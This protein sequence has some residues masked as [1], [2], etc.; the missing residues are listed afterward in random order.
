MNY[1]SEEFYLICC[2]DFIF[3]GKETL[4]EFDK[5]KNV[6]R[7]GGDIVYTG[8][9]RVFGILRRKMFSKYGYKLCF[10]EWQSITLDMY[11][12]LQRAFERGN[13]SNSRLTLV[14]MSDSN[15]PALK[16]NIP[17]WDCYLYVTRTQLFTISKTLPIT[18]YLALFS[19]LCKS[20]NSISFAGNT[21]GII[22]STIM[23]CNHRI[24][25]N[26]WDCNPV[27]KDEVCRYDSSCHT[28]F[29][30]SYPLLLPEE[31]YV[32]CED[33]YYLLYLLLQRVN[34]L[35]DIPYYA[36]EFFTTN[37]DS[38]NMLVLENLK[39]LLSSCDVLCASN[40]LSKLVTR[41]FMIDIINMWK[42]NEVLVRLNNEFS[43]E[44]D[45]KSIIDTGL[46]DGCLDL[47]NLIV[48]PSVKGSEYARN[49]LFLSKTIMYIMNSIGVS[50]KYF[51]REFKRLNG[52]AA[53]WT[54]M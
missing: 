21:C 12:L 7:Y 23:E 4:F 31:S 17:E 45:V 47:F 54:I 8:D 27:I 42:F 39:T 38:S 20:L 25:L 3:N 14:A 6:L 49:M 46:H 32:V 43:N 22:V 35:P 13:S 2:N 5:N 37:F 24:L 41:L 30:G 53:F 10:G 29:C 26:W 18:D 50:Y 19:M 51:L 1:T 36:A 11:S 28:L 9:T 40:M 34:F 44:R 52:G 33:T 15:I 48:D 16:F